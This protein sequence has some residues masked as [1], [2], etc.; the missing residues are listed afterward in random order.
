MSKLWLQA[1]LFLLSISST[2]HESSSSYAGSASSIINPS[3]VKQISWKPRFLS[4]SLPPF[5]SLSLRLWREWIRFDQ[6]QSFR[7][8]RISHGLGVRPFDLPGESTVDRFRWLMWSSKRLK[9]SEFFVIF[10]VFLGI[11]SLNFRPNR[12][13][14]DRQWRIMFRERASSAKS[15]PA[16][17]CSSLRPRFF[18]YIIQNC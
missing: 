13:W 2:F 4:L 10:T 12:S 1:F 18:L 8:R 9:Y 6:L 15:V 16:L 14:R 5:L 17:A 11:F 7:L 3:K